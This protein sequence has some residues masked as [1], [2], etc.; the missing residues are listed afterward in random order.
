[1]KNKL[2]MLTERIRARII[3]VLDIIG[4]YNYID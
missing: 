3:F 1:M 4:K 2:T